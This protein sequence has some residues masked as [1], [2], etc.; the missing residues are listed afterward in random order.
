MGDRD[1]IGFVIALPPECRSLTRQKAK[2]LD[3]VELEDR[4]LIR[5]SG[6]GPANA[7]AAA[8][9]LI[10]RGARRLVSW[11]CAGALAAHLVPGDL[12]LPA[13]AIGSDGA[14]VHFCPQWR[15]QL[16]Q[17]LAGR[18]SVHA[19][20]LAESK[21]IVDASAAKR[22]LHHRTGA[23]AVDMESLAVM[24]TAARQQVPCIAVRAIA[25]DQSTAL[26]TAVLRALNEHGEVRLGALL[27]ALA[28]RPSELFAL[29]HLNR[30]FTAALQSLT[31]IA[32]TAGPRLAA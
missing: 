6:A 22:E 4:C 26:P 10:A 17:R 16:T 31:R 3:T 32:Q 27:L 21:V 28:Q 19:G 18:V 11:G 8:D 24:R 1:P 9:D 14:A 5:V 30:C 13:A 12:I 15:D 25:D 20:P 2:R 7:A 29:L 23:V